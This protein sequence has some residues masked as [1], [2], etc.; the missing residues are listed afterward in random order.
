M[1][2][3]KTSSKDQAK[4]KAPRAPIVPVSASR[5]G[6]GQRPYEPGDVDRGVVESLAA[7]GHSH[8]TI[9]GY[10]GLSPN[11]LRKHYANELFKSGLKLDAAS[12]TGLA[13]G[14]QNGEAWAVLHNL[15]T[16]GRKFG[17]ADRSQEV[18]DLSAILG[19]ADFARFSNQK[20]RQLIDLLALAGV[21]L[22]DQSGV[23]MLTVGNGSTIDAH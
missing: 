16:R 13:K 10:L 19:G 18:A 17:W 8:D 22:P 3:R 23:E 12:I 9:A 5:E 4:R 1:P 7:F 11:T 2:K 15:R 21:T 6:T 20:I 14:L